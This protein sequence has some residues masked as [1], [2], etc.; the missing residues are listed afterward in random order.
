MNAGKAKNNPSS[1]IVILD[2]AEDLFAVRGYR[3]TTIADIAK[4]A[5]MSAAN[6][7]RH[8]ENKEDIAAAC[9]HRCMERKNKAL[10][11]VL[12]RKRLSA[13]ER[14]EEFIV[15]LLRYTYEETQNRPKMN[16]MVEVVICCRPEMVH[17][18]MSNLQSMIA[19]ILAQGNAQKEFAVENVVAM[20]ETVFASIVVFYTP[21]FMHLHPLPEFEHHA[22]AMAELLLRGLTRR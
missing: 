12:D 22:R 7:Y 10:R 16:E 5:N 18:M 13:A 11:E 21:L 2:V 9:A 15:S 4:Q 1:K 20:A 14:L 17:L 19:E 8:F 3:E 6:L